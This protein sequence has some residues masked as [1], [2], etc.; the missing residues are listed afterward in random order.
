MAATVHCQG[1]QATVG[2]RGRVRRPARARG[3]VA[4]V[5]DGTDPIVLQ[6]LKLNAM[7]RQITTMVSG[8]TIGSISKR[9]VFS[10]P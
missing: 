9:S 10:R 4:V 2:A 8:W 7:T 3:T 6:C 5:M 1:A